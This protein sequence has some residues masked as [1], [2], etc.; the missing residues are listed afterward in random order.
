[1]ITLALDNSYDLFVDERGNIA[2]QASELLEIAQTLMNRCS[3]IRG[4]DAYNTSNG[5]NIGIMLG[6]DYTLDDRKN[7]IRRVILMDDR[8]VSIE[9]I[10]YRFDTKSRAGYFTP[11]IKVSLGDGSQQLIQFNLAV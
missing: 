10:E 11:T 9:K 3:L 8:V 4:E 2:T 5:I 6:Q 1:M 7:E